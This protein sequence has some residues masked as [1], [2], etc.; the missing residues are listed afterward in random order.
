MET[1]SFGASYN[2]DIRQLGITVPVSLSYGVARVE[3]H[4]KV[5]SGAS[6]CIFARGHGELLNQ[7]TQDWYST[8]LA[9]LDLGLT[10]EN[11]APEYFSTATGRFKAYRHSVT[12]SVLRYDFDC[13][14]YFAESQSYNRDVLGRQGWIDRIRLG[15]VDYDGKLYLSDY[16]DPAS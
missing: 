12:L 13:V 14:V 9:W 10:I 5:D 4:A 15:L 11:G 3:L 7:A 8:N 6:A 16:N 2:Y 1:L